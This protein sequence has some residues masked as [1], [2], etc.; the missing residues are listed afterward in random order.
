M[1]KSKFSRNLKKNENCWIWRFLIFCTV[2]VTIFFNIIIVIIIIIHIIIIILIFSLP[3]FFSLGGTA[4]EPA[5]FQDSKAKG[6][7]RISMVWVP[8]LGIDPLCE[9]KWLPLQG[10][11]TLSINSKKSFYKSYKQIL[12]NRKIKFSRKRLIR[13]WWLKY[14]AWIKTI[15]DQVLRAVVLS[16]GA[17]RTSW[18]QAPRRKYMGKNIYWILSLKEKAC[19]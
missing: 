4:T 17:G 5:V 7:S 13:S 15:E 11:F 12:K 16:G 6:R 2:T 1:K 14:R 3:T 10:E 9:G 19:W 8:P 18:A